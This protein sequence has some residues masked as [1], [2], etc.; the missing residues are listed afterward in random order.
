MKLN[1]KCLVILALAA[2]IPLGGCGFINKLRARDALNKGV[3]AFTEQKYDEAA[4]YFAESID[5]D[6]DFG[7]ARG[8]TL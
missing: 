5:A 6:P 1:R 7:V 3:K 8:L 2:A 4:K